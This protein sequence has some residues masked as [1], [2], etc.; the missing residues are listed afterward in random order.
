VP[1]N[2]VDQDMWLFDLERDANLQRLTFEP[3]RKLAIAMSRGAR[4]SLDRQT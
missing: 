3:P 1:H 2:V 4:S